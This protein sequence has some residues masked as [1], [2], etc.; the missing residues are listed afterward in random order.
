MKNKTYVFGAFMSLFL[1]SGCVSDQKIQVAQY[2]DGTKNCEQLKYE[3]N[4]LGVTFDDVKDDSG[5]TG[6]NVALGIFFWPGIIVNEQTSK[7]N[8]SSVNDRIG[9]LNKIYADKCIGTN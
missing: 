2:D 4:T 5:L 8:A 9:H 7:R 1:F 6:K 3:L